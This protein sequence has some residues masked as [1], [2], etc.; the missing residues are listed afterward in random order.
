MSEIVRKPFGSYLTDL[1]AR[2]NLSASMVSRMLGHK[3]RTTLRR[4]L[5]EQANIES[6][7][8]F[9][10]DFL[11]AQLFPLTAQEED[12]LKQ[13]LEISRMGLK[14]FLA[15]D[16][17]HQLL[18]SSVHPPARRVILVN[19]TQ[20]GEQ[21]PLSKLFRRLSSA[22]RLRMLIVNSPSGDFFERLGRL[23]AD[24]PACDLAVDHYMFLNTNIARTTQFIANIFPILTASC[25][26]VYAVPHR[27]E[28]IPLFNVQTSFMVICH[29]EFPSG[30]SE[31]YQIGFSAPLSAHLLSSSEKGIYQFWHEMLAPARAL[32]VPIKQAG[33]S[34]G[35]S[36][37]EYAA[38]LDSYRALEQNR[39]I[40]MLKPR[41]SLSLVSPDLLRAL[42]ADGVKKTS[43]P[44]DPESSEAIGEMFR[45][46][47]QRFHNIYHKKR[48]THLVVDPASMRAFVRDGLTTDHFFAMRPFT[49]G[50]RRQILTYCRDQSRDNPYFNLYFL[51]DDFPCLGMEAVCFESAGV[52]FR[53]PGSAHDLAGQ[54]DALITLNDFT[55]LFAQYFRETLL[56][57]H[58]LSASSSISV[59][60][61]LIEELPKE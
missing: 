42:L 56:P 9:L 49:P 58:A 2:H 13:A 37:K 33:L 32:C 5:T 4:I 15:K 26:S 12:G 47:E 40:Y 50:E 18:R 28:D 45:I 36:L 52:L 30:E 34:S 41:L 38:V 46:H 14:N 7:E 60:N 55:A 1:L 19:D 11:C 59:L 8:R 17:L 10:S 61:S 20:T 48:V 51:K 39:A 16:E 54:A 44:D 3:S 24:M 21:F 23:I 25:V 35:I 27:E 57:D 31:E 22:L 6:M 43:L 53:Q 29:A